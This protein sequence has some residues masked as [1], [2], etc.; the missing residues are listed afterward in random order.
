[1]D[2]K[3]IRDNLDLVKKNNETRNVKVNLEDFTRLDEERLDLTRQIDQ[4]RAERNA[5][6]KNKPSEEE[7]KRIRAMGEEISK[8]EVELKAIEEELNKILFM[9]PNINHETTPIA[10]DE[11]GNKVERTV[12]EKPNFSFKAEEHFTIKNVK[13]LIDLERGAKTSGSRFYYLKGKLALLERALFQFTLDT[14]TSKGFELVL[15]PI[16]VQEPAMF[17]TGFF[18]AEKSEIYT[19]NPGEDNLYLV[20]TSEV[21]MIYMYSGE[22]L[23]AKD[24]PKKYVAITPCFRREAG[25]YGK[26]TKGIFR[27]HQFY[28]V[29]IIIFSTPEQSWQLHEEILA[30]EESILQALGLPYQVLNICSGDLGFPAAKKYDC[31]GWFPGQGR[32]RELTSTSNTT[33]YQ[34]RRS[35]IKYKNSEGKREFIH[36]LNGTAV[37]DRCLLAILENNQQEDGSV[38][39]P[40]VLRKY[41]G[42]ENI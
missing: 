38:V 11:S 31:E 23:E 39:V 2:I 28:K 15:P 24:L 32:Y 41:T 21:P 17:G 6:S 40:E 1:L 16:L 8:L 3:F 29:E 37:T 9:I 26:D 20:G 33:D 19:V 10:L 35:N 34:A 25:S 14:I 7:I 18:P 30:H 42:F 5:G 4:L 22:I 12:G 36:T 13:E 27:V